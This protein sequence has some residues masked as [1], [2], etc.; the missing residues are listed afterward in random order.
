MVLVSLADKLRDTAAAKRAA[1]G[2]SGPRPTRRPPQYERMQIQ[3][4]D[5]V[6]HFKNESTRRAFLRQVEVPLINTKANRNALRSSEGVTRL[7][8]EGIISNEFVKPVEI[9]R[10]V[11]VD[12]SKYPGAKLRG[13]EKKRGVSYY[14]PK[15]EGVTVYTSGEQK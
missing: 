6:Y 2:I 15:I 9:G 1:A 8:H 3:M 7:V 5:T 12:R 11:H 4:S 10:T 13:I 14:R